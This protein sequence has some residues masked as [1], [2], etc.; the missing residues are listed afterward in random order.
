MLQNFADKHPQ[1]NE[2]NFVVTA[3]QILYIENKMN[4]KQIKKLNDEDRL[5]PASTE[6]QMRPKFSND[7]EKAN[8]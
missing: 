7:S 5:L 3:R 8:E 6:T 2:A 1:F 4:I